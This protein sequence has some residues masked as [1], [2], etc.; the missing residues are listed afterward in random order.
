MLAN[1]VGDR[2]YQAAWPVPDRDAGADPLGY[3]DAYR[4]AADLVGQGKVGS[5][6]QLEAQ[7]QSHPAAGGF[8]AEQD[9]AQLRVEPQQLRHQGQQRGWRA[10]PERGLAVPG[11][12][13]IFGREWHDD[14]LFLVS[15]VAGEE[16]SRGG[17]DSATAP[18]GEGIRSCR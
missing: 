1:R 14:A 7:G 16:G 11:G 9:E 5:A 4:V 17:E 15:D 10:D 13:G 3:Q 18:A 2:G 8:R 12:D 6:G